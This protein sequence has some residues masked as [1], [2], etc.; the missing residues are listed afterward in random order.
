MSLV[1]IRLKGSN[2]Y[3]RVPREV[4]A[5]EVDAGIAVFTTKNAYRRAR[6]RNRVMARRDARRKRLGI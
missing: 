1:C 3:A 2:H 5:Q 6:K 4:A